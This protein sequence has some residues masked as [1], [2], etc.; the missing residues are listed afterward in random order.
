MKRHALLLS[1]ALALGGQ[2]IAAP[3]KSAEKRRAYPKIIELTP[4]SPTDEPAG[5][6]LISSAITGLD[7]RFL[8]DATLAGLLQS[9]LG[10]LAKAKGAAEQ[11]RRVGETFTATQAEESLQLQRLAS[12]KGVTVPLDAS[13]VRTHL[14][15]GVESL[16]G[17]ADAFT[18]ASARRGPFLIE[19]L[20]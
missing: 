9:Y 13:A 18:S 12:R 6:K 11:V 19:F 20:I 10:E 3:K 7:F 4:P 8:R 14:P 16:E 2:T 1:V 15:G 17:F 5:G